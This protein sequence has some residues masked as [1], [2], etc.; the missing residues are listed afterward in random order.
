MGE[1]EQRVGTVGFVGLHDVELLWVEADFVAN[2]RKELTVNNLFVESK[3]RHDGFSPKTL[4]VAVG[5]GVVGCAGFEHRA[6]DAEGHCDRGDDPLLKLGQH[7]RVDI[8][9]YFLNF[10]FRCFYKETTECIGYA[11]DPCRKLTTEALELCVVH[12]FG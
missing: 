3:P 2:R 10:E 1:F 4:S 7:H 5:G 6:R 8:G 12:R 9:S 11:I